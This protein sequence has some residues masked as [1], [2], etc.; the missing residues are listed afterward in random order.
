M[1]KKKTLMFNSDDTDSQ[2]LQRLSLGTAS[3]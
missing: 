2:S 3:V 1:D